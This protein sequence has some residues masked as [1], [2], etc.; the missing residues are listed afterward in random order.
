MCENIFITTQNCAFLHER[1]L[2]NYGEELHY[3][4]IGNLPHKKTITTA[5]TAIVE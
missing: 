1:V 2:H 5:V 4:H 3:S